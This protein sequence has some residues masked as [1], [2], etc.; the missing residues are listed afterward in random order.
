[1]ARLLEAMQQAVL[2][3]SRHQAIPEREDPGAK[4][5]EVAA[6]VAS[7][8]GTVRWVVRS[9]SHGLSETEVEDLRAAGRLGA[10]VAARRYV[11]RDEAS[12]N[13]FALHHVRGHVLK[14]AY[15]FWG[16]GRVSVGSPT[17]K[18]VFCRE[19]RVRRSL[20]VS[21]EEP[22]HED[23]AA[24]IGVSPDSLAMVSGAVGA[25]DLPLDEPTLCGF[26]TLEETIE[27]EGA[28]D[29]LGVLCDRVAISDLAAA[30]GVLPDRE[31]YVIERRYL[32]GWTLDEVRGELGG[33]TKQRVHQIECRALE[34]L[35]EAL[36]DR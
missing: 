9:Y 31:R 1:M 36:S 28:G 24:A 21:G 34:A 7:V 19:A 14:Q 18:R 6:L 30:L 4:D 12:F 17:A 13:T 20:E 26:H 23:V 3:I 15:H 8:E 32:D 5:R 35:R 25:S 10:V 33:V 27:D 29:P 2:A 11:A 16:R 22:S